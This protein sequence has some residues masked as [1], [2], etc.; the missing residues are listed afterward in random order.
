MEVNTQLLKMRV[1]VGF[2]GEKSQFNW[3]DTNFLSST[4]LKFLEITCPR[5][6][7]SAG[8]HSVFEA[9][10]RLH[11]ARIG[12][13]RVYHLFRLP[14]EV[15]EGLHRL[16]AGPELPV[17]PGMVKEKALSDLKAMAPGGLSAPEGPVQIGTFKNMLTDFA[18]EELAQH[19]ADAFAKGKQTFPYFSG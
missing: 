13:G 3:W 16:L 1:L 7:F 11:D 17:S 14:P 8:C 12:K 19:Y 4:G 9:A 2:L 15:E 18:V 10:A 6:A 5:T